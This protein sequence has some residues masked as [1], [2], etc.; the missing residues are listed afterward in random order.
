M[1]CVG[2]FPLVFKFLCVGICWV[3]KLFKK[4]SRFFLIPIDSHGKQHLAHSLVG[5][6]S[7]TASMQTVT[8]FSN[9]SFGVCL[10]DVTQRVS[11]LFLT[12]IVYSL[13]IC[14]GLWVLVIRCGFDWFC[15]DNSESGRYSFKSGVWLTGQSAIFPLLVY[16]YII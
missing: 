15:W 4:L 14:I 13:F 9:S 1:V 10:S 12:V 6:H 16:E 8:K 3:K 2:F 7:A 5:I 11:N